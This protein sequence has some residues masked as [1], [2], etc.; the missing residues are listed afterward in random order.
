MIEITKLGLLLL[1]VWLV[2]LVGLGL[3]QGCVRDPVERVYVPTPREI[4]I[5][6]WLRMDHRIEY[7]LRRRGL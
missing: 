4:A 3:L 1:A 2:I 6:E 7:E 5:R